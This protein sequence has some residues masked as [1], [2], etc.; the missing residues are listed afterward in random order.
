MKAKKWLGLGLV[1]G[2]M[3]CAAGAGEQP[4]GGVDPVVNVYFLVEFGGE[5]FGGGAREEKVGGPVTCVVVREGTVLVNVD[6]SF[7]L[8][9]SE[10]RSSCTFDNFNGTE[11]RV[12]RGSARV[13]V[14]GAR[15]TIEAQEGTFAPLTFDCL[16]N[17]FGELLCEE[18]GGLSFR[19]E[20][21]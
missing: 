4:P 7:E 1:V 20:P 16:L 8:E 10:T 15:Y 13:D 14:E 5:G 12:L 17:G 21:I 18:S 19:A 11:T 2:L 3:G 6:L 9:A